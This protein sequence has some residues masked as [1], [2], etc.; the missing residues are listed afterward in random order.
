LEHVAPLLAAADLALVNL[1]CALTASKKQWPGAPKAFYFGAPPA[2]VD[3]L[4]GAGIDVVSL[5]NNHALDY[6]V[7]G[8]SDT[9]ALLDAAGIAHAG[10]GLT[11]DE[12]LR[13]AVVER[14]G[15]RLGMAAFCDHQEDFAAS[16]TRPGVAY[17]DLEDEEAARRAFSAAL[18]PLR[19]LAIDWPILSLH[20]GPNM[21]WRPG[22][23]FRRLAHAAVDMGWR[24]IFGHSAH[25]FHGVELFRGC[26]IIYAAGDLVDDYWVDPQ[27]RNDHQFLFELELDIDRLRQL[28][29]HP[30]LIARCQVAPASGEH[31][32]W[33]LSRMETLCREFGTPTRREGRC[34]MVG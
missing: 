34:L 32:D 17:L 18:A 19:A 5:A 3:T 28:R 6:A 20:W 13:A 33:A 14:K 30:L 10:A 23:R 21:V 26:P 9:L 11:L 15:I 16:P 4:R 2:A 7:T 29:L 22:A 24:I 1:E 31:A 27:F 8:L 12:A 25:V